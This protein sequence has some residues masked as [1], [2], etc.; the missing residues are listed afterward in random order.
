MTATRTTATAEVT[1][2]LVAIRLTTGY[3]EILDTG[4]T[5]RQVRHWLKKYGHLHDGFTFSVAP[6]SPMPTAERERALQLQIEAAR[7]L[8]AAA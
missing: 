8:L 5:A 2:Q 3:R 7:Q 6:D 4:L 1:Y